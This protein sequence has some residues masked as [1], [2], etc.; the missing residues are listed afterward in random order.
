[1]Q[2]A[3]AKL[4]EENQLEA[5]ANEYVQYVQPFLWRELEFIRLTCDLAP[6]Q[7]PKI[8]AA[9]DAI[10][11]RVS[12]RVVQGQEGR[13]PTL[14]AQEVRT[15][16]AAALRTELTPQQL[17][18]FQAAGAQRAEGEKQTAILVAVAGID[19]ALFLTHEQRG[20]I[21]HDLAQNWDDQWM[22]WLEMWRYGGRYYPQIPDKLLTPHLTAE[23]R[24]VWSGLRKVNMNAWSSPNNRDPD[25]DA[26][27]SGKVLTQ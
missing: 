1:M 10:V 3:V 17:A 26:W 22:S 18:A 27:W 25:D 13:T 6:A 11:K 8:R 14:A 24:A 16:L 23:Q 5:E 9:G 7:R 12:R 2:A 21:V 19:A 20:Q 4:D 15:Q